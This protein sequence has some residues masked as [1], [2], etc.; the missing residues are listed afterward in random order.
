[1]SPTSAEMAAGKAGRWEK[2]EEKREVEEQPEAALMR[3][4][5]GEERRLATSA[6][7]GTLA[8]KKAALDQDEGGKG[9][10][11]GWRSRGAG[12]TE[13]DRRPLSRRG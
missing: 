12:C 1:V 9:P 11:R 7:P 6:G 2:G 4:S 8:L 5:G 10:R 3:S 13:R